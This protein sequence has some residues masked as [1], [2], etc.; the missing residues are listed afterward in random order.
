MKLPRYVIARKRKNKSGERVDYYFEIPKPQRPRNWPASIRLPDDPVELVKRGREINKRLDA[1]RKG[2]AE[3]GY[4]AQGSLEWLMADWRKSPEWSRLKP[5]TQTFYEQG[6]NH[7]KK[8]SDR[9]KRPHVASIQWPTIYKLVTIY[10]ERPGTQREVINVLQRLFQIATDKG[11]IKENPWANHKNRRWQSKKD[12]QAKQTIDYAG[13]LELAGI[14]DARGFPSMGTAVMIGFD[15]MQ[16]P[17]DIIGM[18]FGTHYSAAERVFRFDRAKTGVPAEIPASAALAARIG[19]Q[20]RMFIVVFEKTGRPYT[21]RHFARVFRDCTKGTKFE[22]FQF[23]WLRHSGVK[24][25]DDCGIDERSIDAMGAWTPGAGKQVRDSNY[26]QHNVQLAADG[27]A[28]RER[29]RNT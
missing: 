18:R 11:I 22:T 20:D 5:K 1:V 14:C 28:K 4:T 27:M 19:E 6:W 7:I 12:R 3:E 9:N 2:E 25:C 16:Y 23:R 10:H 17:E 15:I 8:W 29:F 26:R 24:E 21:R 13:V